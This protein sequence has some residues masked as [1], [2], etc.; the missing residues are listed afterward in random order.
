RAGGEV[1]RASAGGRAHRSLLRLPNGGNH[2]R[3]PVLALLWVPRGPRPHWRVGSVGGAWLSAEAIGSTVLG[4][5]LREATTLRGPTPVAKGSR[6]SHKKPAPPGAL[7]CGIKR[8]C[9]QVI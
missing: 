5:R 4:G 7:R 6:F 8:C 9:R 1:S 2:P 3:V